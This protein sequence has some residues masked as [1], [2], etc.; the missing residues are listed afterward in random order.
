MKTFKEI[1]SWILEH[2][3][4]LARLNT[5]IQNDRHIVAIS[6][7][8]SKLSP[9]EN[10]ARMHELMDKLKKQG[11]G[12]KK[13]KG[14]WEGGSEHSLIVHAK[15]PGNKAGANLVKDMRKLAS[16]YDQDAILHYNQQTGGGRL[17]GTN[18]S[19]FPGKKKVV[20][21]GK[22]R[23]NVDKSKDRTE[24]GGGNFRMGD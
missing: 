17:I 18:D 8:R 2:G 9:Q 22:I 24:L 13:T 12:F 20:K 16:D 15:E 3:N 14:V 6:A 23:Y 19:G 1:R 7:E 11:Y 5:H 4:P 21:L 10:K